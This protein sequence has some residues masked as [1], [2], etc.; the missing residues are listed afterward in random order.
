MMKDYKRLIDFT[1][2]ELIT[3]REIWQTVALPINTPITAWL[4]VYSVEEG[5]TVSRL[6]ALHPRL[7]SCTPTHVCYAVPTHYITGTKQIIVQL[8][9]Y[10]EDLEP[11][12]NNYDSENKRVVVCTK[13][14]AASSESKPIHSF[15]VDTYNLSKANAQTINSS[16]IE[17]LE[18]GQDF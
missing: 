3:E 7:Y 18:P 16:L 17:Q 12:V 9:A 2:D 4:Y 13:C 14:A 5:Q 11:G 1:S 8:A 6:R 15:T 10:Y